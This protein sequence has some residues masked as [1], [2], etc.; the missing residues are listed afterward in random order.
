M[1]FGGRPLLLSDIKA[2]LE[3]FVRFVLGKIED[4]DADVRKEH[5]KGLSV[6]L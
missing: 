3:D 4:T 6:N 5:V 1:I 2:V